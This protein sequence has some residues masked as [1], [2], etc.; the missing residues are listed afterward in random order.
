MSCGDGLSWLQDCC[1]G[2]ANWHALQVYRLIESLYMKTGHVQLLL[3]STRPVGS[4][5]SDRLTSH[6]QCSLECSLRYSQHCPSLQG[7]LAL[8]S[9]WG[10][11]REK[12]SIAGNRTR[13]L[14]SRTALS[15]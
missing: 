14:V 11:S 7:P 2:S 4:I 8:S 10:S 12:S 6:I 9:H 1:A 15:S 3:E 13:D 5:A